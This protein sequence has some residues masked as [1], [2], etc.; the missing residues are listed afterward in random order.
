[1]K[2]TF[3]VTNRSRT[4]VTNRNFLFLFSEARANEISFAGGWSSRVFNVR[5]AAKILALT[6]R[7]VTI[8]EEKEKNV[9]RSQR[10]KLS[11]GWIKSSTL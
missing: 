2:L 4:T 9:P 5:R 11:N 10:G 6:A 7:R 3:Y 1:M 8:L